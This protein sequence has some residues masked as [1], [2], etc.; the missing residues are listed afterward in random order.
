MDLKLY[1]N[2]KHALNYLNLQ[3]A[4]DCEHKL[5]NKEIVW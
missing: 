3:L 5:Y 1:G 4:H 2:E